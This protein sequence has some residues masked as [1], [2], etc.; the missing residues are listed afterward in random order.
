MCFNYKKNLFKYQIISLI[1]IIS[2]LLG[3][4][5]IEFYSLSP[6]SEYITKIINI[7]LSLFSSFTRSFLDTIEKYLIEYDNIYLF[8]ILNLKVL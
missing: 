2:C 1:I 7:S 3:I 5:Y 8:K 6:G 4:I